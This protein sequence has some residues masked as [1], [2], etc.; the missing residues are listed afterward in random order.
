MICDNC[1]KDRLVNDFINNQKFCFH[2]EYQI[3]LSKVPKKRTPKSVLCRICHKEVIRVENLKKRQ[4]T[5]FCSCECAQIGH[6]ELSNNHWTRRV[7]SEG[8]KYGFNIEN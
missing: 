2:C 6:K 1:K 7:R 5:V 4:R 3:K 8:T